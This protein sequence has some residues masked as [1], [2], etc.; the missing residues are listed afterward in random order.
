[1]AKFR[2]VLNITLLHVKDNL[3]STYLNKIL[4]KLERFLKD[5]SW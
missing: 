1:M 2:Q 3:C 5:S 4:I